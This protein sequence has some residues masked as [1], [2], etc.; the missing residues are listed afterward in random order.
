MGNAI[1]GAIKGISS[2]ATRLVLGELSQAWAQSS[3][4][5]VEIESV[6]GVDAAK[7]VQAEEPFDIAFLASDVIEKLTA[8]GHVRSGTKVDLFDSGVAIAVRVGEPWPDIGS[9]AALKKAVLAASKIGYSTGP[10]GVALTKLFERWGIAADIKD[11]IVQAPAGVPVGA[12]LA[13]GEVGLAFQQ[14]SELMNMEGI[15]VIGPMPEGARIDT[16][17]SGGVCTAS[18]NAQAARRFLEYLA[19][20]ETAEVKRRHGMQPAR[21]KE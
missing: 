16:T 9:E 15:E 13:R 4:E 1:K 5:A 18:S 12:L 14:L 8:S 3:G 21:K 19:S 10:S 7:R 2:M 20:P 11:K 6:G 17:F